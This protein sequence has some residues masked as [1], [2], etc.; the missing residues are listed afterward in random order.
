LQANLAQSVSNATAANRATAA[1]AAAATD[2]A[3]QAL[4]IGQANA[5]AID[6]LN[7]KID[8]MFKKRP[9]E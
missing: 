9:T 2:E 5:A 8:Q 7:T 1:A 3:K 4:S 6:K